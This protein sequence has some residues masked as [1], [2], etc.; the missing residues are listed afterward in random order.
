MSGLQDK[1]I[2]ITRDAKG[3]TLFAEKLVAQQAKPKIAS[4]LEITCLGDTQAK[5]LPVEIATCEWIFFTSKNGVDCFLQQPENA[6]ALHGC[7]IAAVGSKTAQ[8]IERHGYKVDFIP[9][10]YNAETMA[11]EFLA[12]YETNGP[13]LFVRGVLA[14]PVLVDAF[15]NANR[16][17][18]CLE[19]Y[20]TTI[21]EAAKERLRWQFAESPIDYLT[22][23]SPSAIDAF[24]QL[25]E[26]QINYKQIPTVC[27]GTTTERRAIKHG[28]TKTI[29]PE[30][31]TIDGMIQ[32]MIKD[33][34]QRG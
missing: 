28:F 4:L 18:Y 10:I 3:A 11:A 34:Q 1:T 24:I 22:F 30:Q 12:T 23:T 8:A 29:V 14:S 17:F 33:C 2:L 31:F 25:I 16:A 19:V 21:N 27:I 6:S 20:D 26:E 32:A 9:S 15:T 13:V 7:H 5:Q